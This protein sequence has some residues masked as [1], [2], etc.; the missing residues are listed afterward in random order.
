MRYLVDQLRVVLP[1]AATDHC[2]IGERVSESEAR[3]DVVGIER[4]IARQKRRHRQVVRKDV[5]L[6]V[7][8][9]AEIHRQLRRHLPVVL[10]PRA[11][12]VP[13]AVEEA[14]AELGA[15]FTRNR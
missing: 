14:T 12:D 4:T 13:R 9:H 7:V 8:P 1:G 15:E 11:E 2:S 10:E 5:G 6:Q 3:R